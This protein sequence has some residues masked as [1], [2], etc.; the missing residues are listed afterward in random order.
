MK[1]FIINVVQSFR[2]RRGGGGGK[3]EEFNFATNSTVE[4]KILVEG[5]NRGR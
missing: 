1:N 4:L 2:P 3:N 5:F